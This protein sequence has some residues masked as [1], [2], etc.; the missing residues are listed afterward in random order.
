MADH[1]ADVVLA[2]GVDHV[3]TLGDVDGHGLLAEDVAAGPGGVDGDVA[4]G[5]VGGGDGDGVAFAVR[6]ERLVIGPERDAVI[7]GQG[8]GGGGVDID[9]A[10]QFELGQAGDH[11]CNFAAE[12]A[13]AD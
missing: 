9:Y 3:V 4:V 1:E 11:L 6:Q 13:S 2:G 8:L 12:A 5:V 10:G 7:F